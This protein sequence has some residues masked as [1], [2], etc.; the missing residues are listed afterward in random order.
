MVM[1]YHCWSCKEE[2]DIDNLEDGDSFT[3]DECQEVNYILCERAIDN[4]EYNEIM[5]DS[6]AALRYEE[7]A[8]GNDRDEYYPADTQSFRDDKWD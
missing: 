6:L 4:D 8:Y 7:A 2:Y 3:C 1:I 5:A